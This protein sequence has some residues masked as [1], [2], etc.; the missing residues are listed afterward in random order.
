MVNV[1]TVIPSI[2]MIRDIRLPYLSPI[3]PKN[4]PPIGLVRNPI[5]NTARLERIWTCSDVAGK[6]VLPIVQENTV[7]TVK[8]KYSRKLPQIAAKKTD[9]GFFIDHLYVLGTVILCII[10]A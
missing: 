10:N 3:Y 8:S 1:G 7:Y 5:A 9:R 2:E 6:K 4:I